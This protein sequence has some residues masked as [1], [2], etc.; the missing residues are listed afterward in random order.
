MPAPQELATHLN[1]IHQE[2]QA[3]LAHS[4]DKMARYYNRKHSPAPNSSPG[5]FVFLFQ[6]NIKTTCPS[7][8]LDY[9]KLDSFEALKKC[10][11]LAY[12]LNLPSLLSHLYLV[13]N[14]D[15]LKPYVDPSII[16]GRDILAPPCIHIKPDLSLGLLKRSLTFTNW[17]TAL[18]I[19]L[20]GGTST[21]MKTHGFLFLMFLA[22]Q[23]N[24]WRLTIINI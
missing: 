14:V 6:Q 13:F 2:L 15:L 7:E 9:Q 11:Q 18:N 19:S 20:S 16:E 23:R 22:P 1:H 8:K 12:L 10:G 4:N 3:E 5:D 21:P 24:F 17:D